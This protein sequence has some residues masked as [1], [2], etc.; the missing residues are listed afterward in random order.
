VTPAGLSIGS[1]LVVVERAGGRLQI[2]SIA[3]P[4]FDSAGAAGTTPA[5][6]DIID[7]Y[8]VFVPK[9]Q[10]LAVQ[11]QRVPAGA[12]AIRVARDG[13]G[14]PLNQKMIEGRSISGMATDGGNYRIEVR[15]LSDQDAAS[16]PYVLSLTLR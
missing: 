10:T 14:A 7:S 3:V 13:T 16:L 12:A 2:V 11:L 4:Q 6:V 8:L 5:P 9:G 15:R 1:N